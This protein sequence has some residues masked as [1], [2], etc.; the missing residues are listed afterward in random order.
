LAYFKGDIFSKIHR[1][2]LASRDGFKGLENF[3]SHFSILFI[4]SLFNCRIRMQ[5]FVLQ[6]GLI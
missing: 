6:E 4:Q 2:K 1:N 3:F 5:A